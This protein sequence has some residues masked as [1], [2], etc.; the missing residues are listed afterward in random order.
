[1]AKLTKAEVSHVAKLAKLHL[2]EKEKEKYLKQLSKVVEFISELE[3][4]DTSAFEAT[5]QTTGLENVHRVDEVKAGATLPQEEA[6]S[7]T[8]NTKNGY[9]EVEAILNKDK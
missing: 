9:F 4:V 2:T 5:S 3:E 8:N 1:M 6:I 7:G